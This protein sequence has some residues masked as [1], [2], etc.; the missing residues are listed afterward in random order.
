MLRF[1]RF[2]YRTVSITENYQGFPYIQRKYVYKCNVNN[3]TNNCNEVQTV[4]Y[5]IGN[6]VVEIDV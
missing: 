6:A 3:T 4:N 2:G 5:N 1:D